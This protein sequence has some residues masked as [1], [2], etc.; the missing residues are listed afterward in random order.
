MGTRVALLLLALPL[1]ACAPDSAAAPAPDPL[2]QRVAE[3]E[4]KLARL[5]VAQGPKGDTGPQGPP[6]PHTK[7]PH[8]VDANGTD[9]GI[10]VGAT[11]AVTAVNGKTAHVYLSGVVDLLFDGAACMGAPYVVSSP[12]GGQLN[13]SAHLITP[14][15]TLARVV[16]GWTQFTHSSTLSVVAGQAHCANAME[17]TFGYPV[18]DTGVKQ[19]SIAST[20][21]TIDLR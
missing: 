6:G 21:L 4:D 9:H 8:L 14:G 7:V 13:G 17:S 11:Q 20:D 19:A 3:L 16:G 2:A 12:D 18:E 1:A 15:G 10:A 5:Q